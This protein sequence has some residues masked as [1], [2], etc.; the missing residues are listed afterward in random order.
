[1]NKEQIKKALGQLAEHKKKFSQ[2]YD[3]IVTLKDLD[4]KS[5]IVDFYVTR[6]F[7]E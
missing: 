6:R 2:K 5:A 4:V 7:L 1:M 3:L